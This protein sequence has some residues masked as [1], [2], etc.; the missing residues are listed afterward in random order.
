MASANS[1]DALLHEMPIFRALSH[2]SVHASQRIVFSAQRSAQVL[3][4]L[5]VAVAVG[6]AACLAPTLPVPPPSAPE[7]S[8]PDTNGEVTV[9]GQK[10]A[11]KSGATIYAINET[12]MESDPACQ[13]NA[14]DAG[15]C[16]FG[17]VTRALDD[18]SYDTKLKA[19]SGDVVY[20]VQTVGNETSNASD[21]VNVP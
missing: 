5:L 6:A 17:A 4:A 10:G 20:V 12:G 11:A 3:R 8:A 7:V 2:G 16:T 18:G 14:V 1:V 15:P 21:P 19:K 9:K 13:V